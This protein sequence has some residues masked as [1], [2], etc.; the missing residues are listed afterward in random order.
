MLERVARNL[1]APVIELLGTGAGS[2]R[3]AESALGTWQAIEAA[4]EPIIGPLGF[5]AIYG[6]AVKLARVEHP[7][8]ADIQGPATAP[9]S[10]QRLHA[11]LQDRP[12]DAAAAAHSTLLVSFC[13]VLSSLVGA[14]LSERLLRTVGDSPSSGTSPEPKP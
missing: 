6:R 9:P 11:V 4:L 13:E 14:A 8:L 10:L 3:I 7:F 2:A 1:A 12:A 5:S